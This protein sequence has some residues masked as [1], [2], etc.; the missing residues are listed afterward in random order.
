[1][2]E[3]GGVVPSRG[4]YPEY[5]AYPD[6]IAYCLTHAGQ[7]L[8]R[9]FLKDDPDA[10]KIEIDALTQQRLL[11]PP[12]TVQFQI[13]KDIEDEFR[14]RAADADR[15]G[16]L[17]PAAEG[18]VEEKRP[19]GGPAKDVVDEILRNCKDAITED[20][21]RTKLLQFVLEQMERSIGTREAEPDEEPLKIDVEEQ[22]VTFRGQ[23]QHFVDV[24]HV[25]ILDVLNK[26]RG[27]SVTRNKMRNAHPLLKHEERLDRLIKAMPPPFNSVIESS[28]EGY[29]LNLTGVE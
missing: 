26:A 1:M 14:N 20:G 15:N 4:I 13:I 8:L 29:T 24:R 27:Y 11:I 28:E 12:G 17:Q 6:Y 5:I 3:L 19:K 21:F 18:G 25:A 2:T 10:R 22:T 7:E 9:R 16:V 23:I